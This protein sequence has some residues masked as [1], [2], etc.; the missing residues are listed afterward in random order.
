M[1]KKLT[2]ED[3]IERARAAHG[4]R[5]DYS[6]VV[7][8][9]SKSHV[10]VAC[11]KHGDFR[12]DP[13][14][15]MSGKGCPK[16]AGRG[17]TDEEHIAR[18]RE[19]HGDRYDYSLFGPYQT[20]KT[21]YIF[22]CRDHGQFKQTADKHL[23]GGCVQCAID[24]RASKKVAGIRETII[25]DFRSV[26]GD[27]FDYSEVEYQYAKEYVTIIC[28]THGRFEQTPDSHKQG[29]GCPACKIET[30]RRKLTKTTE[31][32]LAEARAAHG[33]RYDY[34]KT[35]Y[36]QADQNVVII[37]LDHGEFEQTPSSHQSGSG[38]PK[39]I[40]RGVTTESFI[41][42]CRQ[43]HGDRYDYSKTVYSGM[44]D[45]IIVGCPEHG[46][47]EA[48]AKNHRDGVECYTCG[49]EKASKN[50]ISNRGSTIV[51]EMTDRHDGKYTYENFV[52]SGSSVLSTISCPIHGEFE[53][54]PSNHLGG[55]GCPVC[56][57]ERARQ[58]MV[59]P[60]EEFL[61]RAR[62]A[63]GARYEYRNYISTSTYVDIYCTDCDVWFPQT[64]ESHIRGSGCPSCSSTGFDQTKP[65]R[66]YYLRVDDYVFGPLYKIG[67]TNRSVFERFQKRDLEKITIISRWQFSEGVGALGKETE[68]LRHFKRSKY[69]GE[70]VLT[71]GNS[72]L[73]TKDILGLDPE[74]PEPSH[75]I[76]QNILKEATEIP[77]DLDDQPGL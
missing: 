39:C 25:E 30:I 67:I 15:H 36:V 49:Q 50:K 58:A 52:Y 43:V 24:Y 21:K 54:A 13:T 70:H 5:Y 69:K 22:G 62:K 17:L 63:H 64:G 74:S 9:N 4:D 59:I 18:F 19:I 45:P 61:R 42:Q 77:V 72:E 10:T 7:Y 23:Q 68:I 32:F 44:F 71:S 1:G 27:K 16:C 20:A 35:E 12:T 65:G 73:F 14:N 75:P 11:E 56:G 26:H 76:V 37:C 33:E 53:Q 57:Q 8:R 6:K 46:E 34:S 47:F 41:E 38:C 51:Q 55:Q 31:Q 28:P 29:G 66:L 3:F 2:T 48:S 40:G 60:E